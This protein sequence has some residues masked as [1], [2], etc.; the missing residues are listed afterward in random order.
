MNR[1]ST[2]AKPQFSFYILIIGF[3]FILPNVF[4]I[5][6]IGR[7]GRPPPLQH[8]F[9]N[10]TTF[11]RVVPT[12]FQIVDLITGEIIDEFGNLT[13]E[14]NVVFSTDSSHVVIQNRSGNNEG[15]T[16]TI[17]DVDERKEISKWMFE[18]DFQTAAFHP[19]RPLLAT[20]I[21]DEILFWNWQTGEL[22][23]KMVGNRRQWESCYEYT[24]PN[25]NGATKICSSRPSDHDMEFTPDG[26]HL[27][28]VSM[29]PDIEIW[30]VDTRGLI[31]HF[32]G[33]I[34][35]WVNG[36]AISSNGEYIATY[37]KLDP[38][39]YVWN[40]ETR[41]LL[42]SE[43]VGVGEISNVTFSPNSQH[44]YVATHTARTW[45]SLEKPW[46]GWDDKVSVWNVEAGQQIDVISTEFNGLRAMQLSP[47]GKMA[48]LNYTDAEVFWEIDNKQE[49]SV[50][51]DFLRRWF[52]N[53]VEL[54]PNAK[55]VVS[56]SEHFIKTWDVATQQMQLL[57]SAA[58]YQFDYHAIS[59]DSKSFAVGK[60]PWV[61]VRDIQTG[62]VLTLFP[63]YISG[64]IE[65]TYSPSGRWL[66]VVD[67]FRRV[68]ILDI[69]NP[70]RIQRIKTRIAQ[71]DNPS[72]RHITFSDDDN[73]LAA[74]ALTRN[75]N[76]NKDLD[77]IVLWKLIEDSYEFQYAWRASLGSTP[78]FKK[79]ADGSLL[80]AS[81][82]GE[83]RI[84][85]L[86]PKEPRLL[87]TVDANAYGQVDFS[88][89]GR[90]LYTDEENN[91][92]IW[93]W[94][95]N[96]PAKHTP[97]IPGYVTISQDHSL[98]MSYD[99]N[100]QYLLWD[101]QGILANLPFPVEPKDRQLVTL[102]QI[103]RNQ[104]LQNYPNPFNPET[105]IPFKLADERPVTI[106]IYNSTGKLIR[107]LSQGT[108]KAG[109]YSSQSNAIHWDGQN[110]N[111]EPVSSGVYFYTI[112]AGN[113]SATRK[114]LIRK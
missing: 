55:T 7:I 9:L 17:W 106:D 65:I 54:S 1:L 88:R 21:D 85:K 22:V 34:G 10:N 31:G 42:W 87:T 23:E 49:V 38:T 43:I 50:Y 8:V 76:I 30:D 83:I 18:N 72:F 13:Y 63:H 59:P 3:F 53:R 84:W 99:I 44:L 46:E 33:H 109:D 78:A 95:W 90:F 114:M 37:E 16:I 25:E 19:D 108:L 24:H 79:R 105:W 97:T 75:K 82:A 91:F 62:R 29:R 86:L 94:Q 40:V 41:Q 70:E 12:H 45:T 77:W 4:A 14:T 93:D 57:I 112:N 104:L 113:F 26:K 61:E 89:D 51:A 111:G 32:E 68:S 6:P 48:V 92:Q 103:K 15:Y 60:D 74:S 58:D 5:E 67:D 98:L 36:V 35:N 96:K 11:V 100:V 110:D 80:L 107:T 27:I 52:V 20:S 101:V 47:D 28:V 73:F 39:V 81:P 2:C 66:A 102:G 56:V 64:V 71:D 69:K